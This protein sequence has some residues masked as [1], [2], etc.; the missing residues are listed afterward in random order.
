MTEP[1]YRYRAVKPFE[2]EQSMLFFGRDEEIGQLAELIFSNKLTVLYGKS[3]YGK[4][5]LLNAGI[6]PR[7][8]KEND[9][10]QKMYLPVPVRFQTYEKGGESLMQKFRF[11]F[12]RAMEKQG[13]PNATNP[14]A[15]PDTLWGLFKTMQ[16][17]ENSVFVLLFDQFEEFFSYPIAQKDSFKE[18][19]SELINTS[20]PAFVR[21]NRSQLDEPTLDFL[22][23]ELQIRSLFAIREDRL[24]ELDALSRPL[25]AILKNRMKL[26]ALAPAQAREAILYPAALDNENARFKTEKFGY[27]KTALEKIENALLDSETRR[28]ESFVLQIICFSIEKTVERLGLK[29]VRPENLPNFD[30]VFDTYYRE[31]LAELDE[32][33]RAAAADMLENKLLFYDADTQAAHRRSV[34]AL[35]LAAPPDLL[36]ALERTY[37]IRREVNSLARDSFEIS[38][39]T[40]MEPIFKQR[41]IKDAAAAKVR[42]ENERLEA[43]K[44]ARA[45]EAEKRALAEAALRRIA[46]QQRQRAKWFALGA[47]LAAA[48]ALGAAVWA[49]T[50]KKQA[51]ELTQTTKQQ[52]TEIENTLSE[53]QRTQAAKQKLEFKNL[54]SRATIILDAEGCPEAILQEM[55]GI[56]DGHPDSIAF[57]ASIQQL[58]QKSKNCQ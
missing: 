58:T 1:I 16:P 44:R 28:I 3:G 6:L 11:H 8:K 20:Y 55:T 38:H 9:K 30:E 29:E 32:K 26:G 34:D 35:E 40:L 2:E 42:K 27:E 14:V 36:E 13:I 33:H 50:L 5:S 17:K 53:I 52:K 51:E 19:L 45:A 46:E 54:E 18:Q 43:E 49:Y 41:K 25:D 48:V 22:S 12:G 57:R 23:G 39:D 7:L 4:S 37:L 21:E 56:A 47:G 31:Q 15:L 24:S 10:A